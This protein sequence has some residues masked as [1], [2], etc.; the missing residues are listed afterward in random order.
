MLMAR[1]AW[2]EAWREEHGKRFIKEVSAVLGISW[3]SRGHLLCISWASPGHLLGISW[4]SPG[5]LLCALGVPGADERGE[6]AIGA[7]GGVRA[8]R[9]HD[10]TCEVDVVLKWHEAIGGAMQEQCGRGESGQRRRVLEAVSKV[11]AYR[12]D[13]VW[14]RADH[15]CPREAH[16]RF[17]HGDVCPQTRARTAVW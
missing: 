10:G 16:R 1:G 14:K 11:L 5:H 6:S 3:A 8:A 17:G 13:A 9:G 2:R 12:G 7:I 4:A 15:D